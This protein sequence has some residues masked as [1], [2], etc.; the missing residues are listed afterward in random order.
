MPPTALAAPEALRRLKALY[1]Q[2]AYV[3]L[4]ARIRLGHAGY[5]VVE[6]HLP[7]TGRILDLGCGYG[8]FSN[9][10][11]LMSPEREIVGI[12][13]NARKLRYADKGLR[14]VRFQEL[15]I[16]QDAGAGRFDGI[17]LLHVLHHLLSYAEQET[18]L[19]RCGEL[20]NPGGK[21]VILEIDD[22]PWWK[23]A[24]CWLVDHTLY[25]G[26]TIFF[27]NRAGFLGL[28]ERLGLKVEAVVEM[29]KGRPLPH[30]LYACSRPEGA[31]AKP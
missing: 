31:A 26:D 13:L 21:L 10:L 18:L 27:R 19:K 7:K 12:E 5:D 23:F 22:R 9:Y 15:D 29:Q 3:R 30:I 17:V 16:L 1:T 4:F 25:P 28:F 6:P 14:G 24:L 8:L 2:P 20:L 11:A